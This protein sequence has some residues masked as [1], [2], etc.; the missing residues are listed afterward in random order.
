MK[1][2]IEKVR[3]AAN[4]QWTLDQHSAAKKRSPNPCCHLA[5]SYNRIKKI[6]GTL[7]KDSIK[8]ENKS[9]NTIWT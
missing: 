9:Y 1:E 7:S 4:Q 2:E 8:P 5:S 6:M 3:I